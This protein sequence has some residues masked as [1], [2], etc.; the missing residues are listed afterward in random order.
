ML[1]LPCFL[2]SAERNVGIWDSFPH[3]SLLVNCLMSELLFLFIGPLSFRVFC[4]VAVLGVGCLFKTTNSTP[5]SCLL[6][7]PKHPEMIK[8][9]QLIKDFFFALLH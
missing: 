6:F 8:L 9:P 3:Q 2:M 1:S 5:S 7:H 4:F